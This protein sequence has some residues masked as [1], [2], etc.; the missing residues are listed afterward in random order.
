MLLCCDAD[1]AR[2]AMTMILR[3]LTTKEPAAGADPVDALIQAPERK[4]TAVRQGLSLRPGLSG[5]EIHCTE[6]RISGP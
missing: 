3:L 5:Q 2:R 1:L 6:T 4:G